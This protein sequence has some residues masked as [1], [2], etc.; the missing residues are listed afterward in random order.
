MNATYKHY[1]EGRCEVPR[2]SFG[3]PRTCIFAFGSPQEAEKVAALQVMEP[4]I[5]GLSDHE[6]V[7]PHIRMCIYI[8]GSFSFVGL[9]KPGP[10]IEEH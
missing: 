4:S 9:Q 10:E 7:Y 2:S 8:Y 3:C 5:V 6:P 1:V